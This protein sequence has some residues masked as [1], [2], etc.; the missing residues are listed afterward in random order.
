[1]FFSTSTG[2]T[3]N[4]AV[5]GTDDFEY[6]GVSLYGKTSVAGFDLL[7]DVSATWLK[8]DFTIGG[9]A[10]VDTDT[11]TAVYSFGVQGEKKFKSDL[12]DVVG[13]LH[14]VYRC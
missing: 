8:S 5:D 2:K 1:M 13:R 10:D 9:A 4:D 3:E 6:Y 12:R 11:T 7:G 14:A